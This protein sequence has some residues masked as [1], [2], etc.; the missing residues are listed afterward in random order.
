[1]RREKLVTGEY[2][3]VYNRGT[4]KRLLFNDDH[5]RTRFLY[6]LAKQH[7]KGEVV[8][9]AFVIMDNHIH[10]LLRQNE[11]GGISRFMHGLCLEYAMYFN[12]RHERTG[13]LFAGRF[14]AKR[15]ADDVYL[16]WL[17][18]YIHLNPADLLHGKPLDTYRWSSY[19][20][21]LGLEWLPY[22]SAD[23]VLDMIGG[24]ERYRYFTETGTADLRDPVL[25]FTCPGLKKDVDDK[26]K[27]G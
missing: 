18:R 17:T 1:M 6:I 12:W 22:V 2:Y 16:L 20:H 23:L 9:V 7:S 10:F 5:D 11:D 19:R 3:H 8:I 24:H 25:P 4:D 13:C 14:H 15:V 27:I 21:Y 26:Q